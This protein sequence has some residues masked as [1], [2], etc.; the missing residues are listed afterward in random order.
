MESP[1]NQEKQPPLCSL[2]GI[3]DLSRTDRIST[4]KIEEKKKKKEMMVG[5]RGSKLLNDKVTATSD[6]D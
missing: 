5:E 6:S 1:I 4:K 3:A 2:R